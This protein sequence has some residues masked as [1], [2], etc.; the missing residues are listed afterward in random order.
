MKHNFF[1]SPPYIHRYVPCTYASA[2][3]CYETY[4]MLITLGRWAVLCEFVN[5]ALY[6]ARTGKKASTEY[7][8]MRQYNI[9][10]YGESGLIFLLCVFFFFFFWRGRVC[11][12]IAAFLYPRRGRVVNEFTIE[13]EPSNKA[14]Y[15]RL[16]LG[17]FKSVYG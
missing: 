7:F 11:V 9:Y 1:S 6:R 3:K 13:V 8:R 15:F 17:W 14:F 12:F 16:I 5:K 2:I 4:F 10:T